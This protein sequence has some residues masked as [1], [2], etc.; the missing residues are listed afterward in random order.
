MASF[1]KSHQTGICLV[2]LFVRKAIDSLIVP[3]LGTHY[4]ARNRN[5]SGFLIPFAIC[6]WVN[7]KKS[8]SVCN[9]KYIK[10]ARLLKKKNAI[11][12]FYLKGHFIFVVMR[13]IPDHTP[14]KKALNLCDT[15]NEVT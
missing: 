1:I 5:D 14:K 11:F 6:N 12:D 2:F 10:T 15:D 9:S 13:L 3:S 8:H 4:P 7:N